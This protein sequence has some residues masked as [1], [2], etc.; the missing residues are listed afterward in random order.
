MSCLNRWSFSA[1]FYTPTTP[2]HLTQPSNHTSAKGFPTTSSVG[3]EQNLERTAG[4][5]RVDRR[6]QKVKGL[7]QRLQEENHYLK[8]EI[9]NALGFEEIVGQS[10]PLRRTLAQIE[11]MAATDASVL[12]LGETGTGQEQR[13]SRSESVIAGLPPACRSDPRRTRRSKCAARWDRAACSIA[14]AIVFRRYS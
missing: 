1:A 2:I 12:L 7:T 13:L 8:E 10:E 6:S 14:A 3:C 9:V 4:F 11:Q 5:E